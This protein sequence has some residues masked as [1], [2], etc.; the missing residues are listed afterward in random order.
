M[1]RS[2]RLVFIALGGMALLF[3]VIQLARQSGAALVKGPY[4]QNTTATSATIMWQTGG[5]ISGL[6]EYGDPAVQASDPDPSAFH[7]VKLT[8]LQQGT[9][10]R[11]RVSLDG[12]TV[13][14]EWYTF[15]TA[16]AADQ[17]FRL[18]VYG[19][20]YSQP[21]VHQQI[22]R[23]IRAA[24]PA[25][26]LHTGD[27]VREGQSA[28]WWQK[29]F[30]DPADP[31]LHTTPLY[32]AIGTR[33]KLSI[34]YFALFLP[35]GNGQWYAFSYGSARI[36]A[37]D[38][39]ADYDP[40]ST[41]IQWLLDEFQS[42]EYRAAP[43]HLVFFHTPPFSSA[44]P[45]GDPVVAST[46]VPLFEQHGVQ[47]VFSGQNASYERSEKDGITY[48]VTAG[49]GA[50]LV[51]FAADPL[52]ANPYSVAQVKRYHYCL[53]DISPA[54]IDFAAWDLAGNAIDRTTI[55]G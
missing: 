5:V 29:D 13:W 54:Q 6:L 40:A 4:L 35:P 7:A 36:I 47:I 43:W 14:S 3:V 33:E 8:G 32:P 48:I 1:F 27:L 42:P 9:R 51:D 45:G 53:L 46:L 15:Q 25:L 16:P 24:Q 50:P 34:Y 30:F 20:S 10:Y 41:Q 21:D 26:V 44:G 2:S 52:A 22:I 19:A 38:T 49:A 18:A 37:L 39:N 12:G 55:T 31:L 11:Y 23:E 28:E 17:P